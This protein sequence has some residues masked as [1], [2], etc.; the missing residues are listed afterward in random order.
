MRPFTVMKSSMLL[1]LLLLALAGCTTQPAV[2]SW[3]DP[4]SVA[5]ITAPS[6][7][8]ILARVVPASKTKRS[9]AHIAAVEVNRMGARSLYLVLIPRITGELTQKQRALFERSFD[10]IEIRAGGRAIA[11]SPYTGDVAELGIG[12]PALLPISKSPRFYYPIERTELEAIAAA[13]RIELMALGLSTPHIY[14]EWSA[15][16]REL[17]EFVNQLPDVSS[18]V[19][20]GAAP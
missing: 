4:V 7:P 1:L 19:R 14:E 20:Q 5:T 15:S 18:T 9:S 17:V 10:Q 8:M 13:E 12:E 2:K 3:L 6:E 16:R 11:L